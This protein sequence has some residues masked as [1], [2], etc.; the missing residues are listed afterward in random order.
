MVPS[1]TQWLISLNTTVAISQIVLAPV[2]AL[3]DGVAPA[4][5]T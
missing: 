3:A 2:P 4:P 5:T 1:R